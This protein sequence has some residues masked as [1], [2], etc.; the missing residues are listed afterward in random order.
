[1][2]EMMGGDGGASEADGKVVDADGCGEL[3]AMAVMMVVMIAC[4]NKGYLEFWRCFK[5]I[6][7]EVDEI[8]LQG[9]HQ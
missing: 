1:M 6:F 4:C 7:T 8:S 9:K 2:I 5:I 3:Q